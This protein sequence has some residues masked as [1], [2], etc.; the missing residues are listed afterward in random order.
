MKIEIDQSYINWLNSKE[1]V[2]EPLSTEELTEYINEVL[3]E[4]KNSWDSLCEE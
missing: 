3:Q 1:L 2:T 4:H